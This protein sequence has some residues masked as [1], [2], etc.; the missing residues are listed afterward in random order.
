MKKRLSDLNAGGNHD[1]RKTQN[2]KSHEHGTGNVPCFYLRFDFLHHSQSNQSSFFTLIELLVVIAIIAILAGMLL[3]ALNSAK[4]TARSIAC[5]N[6][7]KQNSTLSHLYMDTYN[8][9]QLIKSPA[10]YDAY[11]WSYYMILQKDGKGTGA[12]VLD[13]SHNIFFCPELKG[14]VRNPVK[15]RDDYAETYYT[16][17]S[18]LYFMS[19]D[20]MKNPFKKE[21]TIDGKKYHSIIQNQIKNPSHTLYLGDSISKS[22]WLTGEKIGTYACEMFFMSGQ[23]DSANEKRLSFIHKRLLT[24]LY[25]DGHA[26]LFAPSVLKNDVTVLTGN[27]N[28]QAMYWDE[29]LNSIRF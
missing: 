15:V 3:P 2:F 5:V 13:K 1:V 18:G 12:R 25:H 8:G 24:I 10:K 4:K 11:F 7:L 26:G 29:N 23:T 17:G 19:F 22:K 28:S 21:E 20:S 9:V 6:N 16:Y 14:N 27:P